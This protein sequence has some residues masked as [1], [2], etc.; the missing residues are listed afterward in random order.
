[1]STIVAIANRSLY[2]WS[3]DKNRS[4][5]G[6][7][8]HHDEPQ[9]GDHVASVREEVS[10]ADLAVFQALWEHYRQD[11]REYWVRSN[12]YLVVQAL[13]LS[14]FVGTSDL[15][16]SNLTDLTRIVLTCV[17]LVVAAMWYYVLRGSLSWLNAW[18]E[19]LERVDREVDRFAAF[20]E[21]EGALRRTRSPAA[22][23]QFLPLVFIAAWAAFLVGGLVTL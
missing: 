21:V 23:S 15:S 7:G 16:D 20:A 10:G 11:L 8:A 13:L 1:M 5:P 6:D 17:G 19:K 18:R 4:L 12:L 9:E 14:V 3:V 2:R 22:V